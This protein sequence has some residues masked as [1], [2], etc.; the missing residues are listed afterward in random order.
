[1]GMRPTQDETGRAPLALSFERRPLMTSKL[2]GR[3]RVATKTDTDE[4]R[5]L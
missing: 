2:A 5:G 1:M 4:N 3:H